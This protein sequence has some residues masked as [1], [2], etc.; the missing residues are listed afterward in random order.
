MHTFFR[1]SVEIVTDS[2][3]L[4]SEPHDLE[5]GPSG[6]NKTSEIYYTPTENLNTNPISPPNIKHDRTY[7]PS[8][9]KLEGNEPET[10]HVPFSD[11]N[12][13]VNSKASERFYTPTD[14]I[15]TYPTTESRNVFDEQIV[16][17]SNNINH[18]TIPSTDEN[19]NSEINRPKNIRF[20]DST[21]T[22]KPSRTIIKQDPMLVRINFEEESKEHLV[23]YLS[24]H[25]TESSN[26]KEMMVKLKPGGIELCG[27]KVK[28]IISLRS[29][30]F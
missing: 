23:D 24:N 11:V 18:E 2:K 22:T 12:N 30:F 14:I 25:F 7:F 1:S 4:V 3:F 28:K 5:S 29:T 6:E 27:S 26:W 19:E 8:P 16:Q 20:S 10:S 15:T 21:A 17:E 9:L 13:D